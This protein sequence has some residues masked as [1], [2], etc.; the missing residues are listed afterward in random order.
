M[1]C[2][3]ALPGWLTDERQGMTLATWCLVAATGAL[4]LTGII[5]IVFTWFQL[6]ADRKQRRVENLAKIMDGFH[7][8]RMRVHRIRF[9]TARLYGGKLGPKD[10]SEFP[11]C[12]MD[13]LDFCEYVGFLAKEGH[14]DPRQVW[15]V[16]GN[17]I[18]AYNQ[19]LG[20][21][22]ERRRSREK[23]TYQDFLW[24]VAKLREIDKEEE[25]AFFTHYTDQD[26]ERL[27]IYD[28]KLEK[29]T[30]ISQE[31]CTLSEAARAWSC[32]RERERSVHE[33][34]FCCLSY[35]RPQ[36]ASSSRT[37]VEFV[38]NGRARFCRKKSRLREKDPPRSFLVLRFVFWCYDF[39]DAN[40]RQP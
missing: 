29:R 9:A 10:E 12:A 5:A 14:L 1:A 25:G 13:V 36:S 27:Y 11:D 6:R 3:I 26:L 20:A 33:S 24:L 23:A 39:P 34:S 17:W 4:V 28:S 35:G 32:F 15:N 2:L 30:L 18:G 37:R 22:I 40:A 8:G 19:D 16:L 38:P 31:R 21:H 7:D